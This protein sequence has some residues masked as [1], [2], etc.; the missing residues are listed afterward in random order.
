MMTMTM[1]KI[2]DCLTHFEPKQIKLK[3]KKEFYL[4][5]IIAHINRTQPVLYNSVIWASFC[6]RKMSNE[7]FKNK[8]TF[9]V[10]NISI[11]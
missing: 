8:Q 9:V 4:Y 3:F 2:V 6:K 10:R 5:N 11:S 1:Q 7:S